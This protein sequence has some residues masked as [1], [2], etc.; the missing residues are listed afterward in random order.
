[1]RHTLFWF[2]CGAVLYPCIE[3]LYRGYSHYS[4]ALAG[5]LCAV[6]LY[7]LNGLYP[8]LPRA[9]RA[10]LGAALICLVEFVCGVVFNIFL[11]QAVWDYS[12]LPF[13]LLGQVCLRFFA[14]WCVFAFF[15][16]LLFERVWQRR[17]A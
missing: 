1:M 14:I 2:V 15:L 7:Y 6:L 13:N 5:G 8:A 10:L 16:A 4:M 17:R 11:G 3:V 12:S 9:L